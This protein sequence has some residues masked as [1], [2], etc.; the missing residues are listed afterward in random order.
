MAQ[1][2]K[3]ARQRC[4]AQ[5]SSAAVPA[6][7]APGDRRPGSGRR[8]TTREQSAAPRPCA[9][10]AGALRFSSTAS[11]ALC[12]RLD[13]P[14]G[15]SALPLRGAQGA[16]SSLSASHRRRCRRAGRLLPNAAPAWA[17]CTPWGATQRL[18]PGRQGSLPATLARPRVP[19]SCKCARQ[20]GSVGLEARQSWQP[21]ARARRTPPTPTPRPVRSGGPKR[22]P[23][24]ISVASS[25]WAVG[26]DG[27]PVG[28]HASTAAAAPAAGVGSAC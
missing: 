6:F 1:H 27:A 4:A 28:P 26:R 8:Q 16:A 20:T 14:A 17:W 24:R 5:C 7:R 19:A 25:L 12:A 13:R 18:A 15:R 2:R 3:A 11:L 21:P 10:A 9:Y 23:C 22:R